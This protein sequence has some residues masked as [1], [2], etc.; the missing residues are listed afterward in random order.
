MLP[1]SVP[2]GWLDEQ[3]PK[4]HLR[5]GS[6][7]NPS[8]GRG[9]LERLPQGASFPDPDLTLKIHPPESLKQNSGEETELPSSAPQLE[10]QSA[11]RRRSGRP[12]LLTA[13]LSTALG[14]RQNEARGTRAKACQSALRIGVEHHRQPPGT[15]Q[16]AAWVRKRSGGLR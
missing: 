1:C 13:Q 6:L 2:C 8:F 3:W 15:L 16:H 14:R 9:A 4:T 7:D 11:A 5:E 12:A 10:T